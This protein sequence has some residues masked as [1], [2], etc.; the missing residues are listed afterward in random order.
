MIISDSTSLIILFDLERVELLS[1][2]FAKIYIPDAV[3]EEINFKE[4]ITLPSF[5]EIVKVENSELLNSLKNLLD[6]GESE[7]ITL[8]KEKSLSLIIDEKKGRKIAQTLDV[9]IIGLLG[10]IYLNVKKEFLSKKEAEQFLLS[11]I[12][13]GY[14]INKKLIDDMM[15]S[16]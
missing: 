4:V 16:L 6:I 3:Y 15:E 5:I 9:Q 13:H 2:L 7:A 8:A 14:R 10:I 1:N 11:A 12:N